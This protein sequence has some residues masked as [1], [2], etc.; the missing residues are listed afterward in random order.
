VVKSPSNFQ[1]IMVKE[2]GEEEI[3]QVMVPGTDL[4]LIEVAA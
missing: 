4:R 3:F 2:D 1:P